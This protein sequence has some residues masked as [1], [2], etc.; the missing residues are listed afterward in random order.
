MP[1]EIS[2]EA[3]ASRTSPIAPSRKTMLTA[4]QTG[5]LAIGTLPTS[6][7]PLSS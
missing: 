1:A 7:S 3:E 2:E 6:G 4:L 5:L